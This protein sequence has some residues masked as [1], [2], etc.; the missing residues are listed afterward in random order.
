MPASRAASCAWCR[1]GRTNLCA[2][3]YTL[4]LS[5][6]GGLA[7]VRRRAGEHAASRFPD[8]CADVDAALAQPLA[9]GLHAVS[10]S[11]VRPGDTVVILGA[12]AI[13]S[14]VLRRARPATTAPSSPLD[15]DAGRLET[16]RELGATETAPD[17]RATRR[18]DELR[19][20]IPDGADVVIESSGVPGARPARVRAGGPR[21][22]RC[23]WSG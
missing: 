6:H 1:R 15:I 12:G 16:A 20:L 3:Y 8:G 2:R 19:D 4:G 5:T 21:R 18:P 13:G 22:Y 17:R 7:R 23:C 9:V 11:G 10:R 14:F